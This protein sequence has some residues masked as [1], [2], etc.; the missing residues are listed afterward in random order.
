MMGEKEQIINI[1]V[2]GTVSFTLFLLVIFLS[3]V[4]CYQRHI[5]KMCPNCTAGDTPISESTKKSPDYNSRDPK[6]TLFPYP[7]PIP[8]S[9]PFPDDR[10]PLPYTRP[11][12]NQLVPY[13]HSHMIP[14]HPPF[15]TNRTIIS[16]PLP[17]VP[18][19]LPNPISIILL[20]I[21]YMYWDAK[22][23]D[24]TFLS[25]VQQILIRV[26]EEPEVISNHGARAFVKHLRDEIMA[27]ADELREQ[28]C[29]GVLSQ[30]P[31]ISSNGSIDNSIKL[32]DDSAERMKKSS[33]EKVKLQ[34]N[35]SKG[36]TKSVNE[37]GS[38]TTDCC[39]QMNAEA[40]LEDLKIEET[41]GGVVHELED[42][43]TT[44]KHLASV[45]TSWISVH[46]NVDKSD[47]VKT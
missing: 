38:G 30:Q 18:G 46:D 22:A 47:Q 29:R 31:T 19:Q 11:A 36:G 17:P 21:G 32:V 40:T 12:Y 16:S 39:S 14:G 34:Q 5:R 25:S 43:I 1:T 13:S 4:V 42:T 8:D 28:R 6:H 37:L 44:M 15:S 9:L 27:F 41:D 3:C 24:T 33:N 2:L 45:L 23:S 20:H 10:L 7:S 26:L 35:K